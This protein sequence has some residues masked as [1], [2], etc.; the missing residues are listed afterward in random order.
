M[1]GLEKLIVFYI[2]F[3]VGIFYFAIKGEEDSRKDVVEYCLNVN[4]QI[5]K[6]S[7]GTVGCIEPKKSVQ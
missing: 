5:Y 2:A 1:E 4:G 3:V 6:E 7:D